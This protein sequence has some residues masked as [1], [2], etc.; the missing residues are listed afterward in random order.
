[1]ISWKKLYAD[2]FAKLTEVLFYV[3]FGESIRKLVDVDLMVW[4]T[5]FQ[6]DGNVANFYRFLEEI[7]FVFRRGFCVGMILVFLL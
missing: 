7:L 5:V 3:F 1:L 4:E 6:Y 2:N